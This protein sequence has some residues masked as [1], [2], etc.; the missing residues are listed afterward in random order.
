M[1]TE[2]YLYDCTTR[3]A[4]KLFLTKSCAEIIASGASFNEIIIRTIFMSVNAIQN[5]LRQEL[6]LVIH[7]YD[8]R[9][10]KVN[11]HFEGL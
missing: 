9:M 11:L 2:K 6:I 10:S 7:G 8:Q 1:A 4:N 3:W 5:L